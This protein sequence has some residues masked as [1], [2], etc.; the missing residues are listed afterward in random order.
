MVHSQ[1]RRYLSVV[2]AVAAGLMP[3]ALHAQD[4]PNKPVR[5]IVPF[6]P[7]G[8]ADASGRLIATGLSNLLGQQVV[9]ENRPGAGA[10]IGAGIAARSAP[11]GYT[12]LL[13]S[14]ALAINPAV[15]KNLPYDL[16][17]DF[18]PVGL[19]MGTSLVL[20]ASRSSGIR[21]V[22]DLLAKAK[23][24]PGKLT[25]GSAGV[26]SGS[27]LAGEIFSQTAQVKLLHVPFGGSG[28][29]T[30][31]VAAGDVDLTFTSQAGALA[32]S[33]ADKVTSLAI[34]GKN[35]STLFPGVPTIEAAGVKG[36][37]A[38]DWIGVL[39][40][41]GTPQAILNKLNAEL[42]KWLKQ[43]ETEGK[44]GQMAFEVDYRHPEQ[45]STLLRGELG[46]WKQAATAA[47]VKP[48]E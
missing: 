21:T 47:G 3:L 48:E 44:L 46:K 30:T 28:P 33:K 10:S 16:I 19:A 24:S 27:H 9:V 22:A 38:G 42:A 6:A 4:Y 34:T 29:A 37:E 40:P 15:K 31:A 12:L 13:A 23:A 26:G 20:V 14:S 35:P 18:E 2:L 5:L 39:A 41:K 25:F 45:F 17:Q 36:Y 8:N 11:D 43:P 32:L 7:G 1:L